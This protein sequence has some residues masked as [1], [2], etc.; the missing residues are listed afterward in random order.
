MEAP[1]GTRRPSSPAPVVTKACCIDD[2]RVPSPSTLPR[3]LRPRKGLRRSRGGDGS[4]KP[5]SDRLDFHREVRREDSEPDPHRIAPRG[6]AVGLRLD[7]VDHRRRRGSLRHPR[8]HPTPTTPSGSTP[9]SSSRR[10]RATTAGL[11]ARRKHV[12]SWKPGETISVPACG[13]K[14]R[15]TLTTGG[16]TARFSYANGQLFR[17]FGRKEVPVAP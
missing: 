11:S 6:C 2:I 5:R 3:L 17:V 9:S 16:E 7:G 13:T 14:I 8:R 12:G 4:R 10:S 15:F 1:T